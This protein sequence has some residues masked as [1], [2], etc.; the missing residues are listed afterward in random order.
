[1]RDLEFHPDAVAELLSAEEW[2]AERS[3][4]AAR[5]F[6]RESNLVFDLLQQAPERWPMD[7]DGSRRAHFARF[8]F[9]VIYRVRGDHVEVIAV[10][11]QRRQPGYWKSRLGARRS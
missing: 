4:I 6:I 1:M 8:P 10:A 11:H 5:S 3:V 2:Y 7:E 9:S